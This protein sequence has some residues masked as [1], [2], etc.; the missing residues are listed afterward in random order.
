MKLMAAR[1]RVYFTEDNIRLMNNY[2]VHLRFICANHNFSFTWAQIIK[3]KLSFTTTF[4]NN[5]TPLKRIFKIPYQQL[6][7]IRRNKLWVLRVWKKNALNA[8]KMNFDISNSSFRKFSLFIKFS[9]LARLE[10]WEWYL[11]MSNRHFNWMKKVCLEEFLWCIVNMVISYSSSFNLWFLA[12]NEL[13]SFFKKKSFIWLK[14][15]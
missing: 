6:I 5:Y 15:I 3:R 1:S 10:I 2:D 11:F 8:L 14:Y 4:G 9:N 7:E 12:E 13:I